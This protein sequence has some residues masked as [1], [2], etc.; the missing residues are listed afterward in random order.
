MEELQVDPLVAADRAAKVRGEQES[1]VSHLGGN[2]PQVSAAIFGAGLQ[3]KAQEFLSLV[4]QG[5][6]VRISHAERMV[7][8]GED[9]VGLAGRVGD[10]DQDNSTCLGDGSVWA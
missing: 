5:H 1:W 4:D 9:L 7:K 2:R 8:A 10:A 6:S 3:E